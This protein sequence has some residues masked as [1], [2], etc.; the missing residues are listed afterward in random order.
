MLE[1]AVAVIRDLWSGETVTYRGE[2]YEVDNA[3]LYTLP[4]VPPPIYMSGFGPKATRM[5]ARIAEGYQ[6]TKPDR[7]LL[8]LFRREN[9]GPTQA[10][11]KVC[12]APTE[13]EGVAIA[14]RLW[15]HAGLPGEVSQL[16]PSP[17]QF[18][19]LGAYVDPE[20]TRESVACG[21]DPE[22]QAAAFR[23]YLDAGFDEVYVGNIGPHYAA[24]IRQFGER[25]LPAVRGLRAA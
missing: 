19:E 21:A 17:Q 14:H 4:D 7:E 9:P 6:T 23:P 15:G 13:D 20:R 5:A 18:A 3:R 16:L 25:V 8:R 22:R 24:M 2:F 1:E 10:G 12:Q 11:L